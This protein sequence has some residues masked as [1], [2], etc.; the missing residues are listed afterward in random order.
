[1]IGTCLKRAERVGFHRWRKT[2][3]ET[4]VNNGNDIVLVVDYHLENLE[5][6][7]L[8]QATGEERC[9]RSKN[10]SRE[11]L[12]L[13]Q[14]AQVE[15]D[16]RGAKVVWIM[17]STSGW[18]RVK[19][20]LGDRAEFLLANVLQMP[21]PPK[22]RR[23][24]TDKI[25]TARMLREYCNGTLPLAYQPLAELRQVRRLVDARQDLVRRQTALKNW[26]SHYLSHET[27]YGTDNLWSDRGLKRLKSLAL[28]KTDRWLLDLK[29]TELEQVLLLVEQV[30]CQIMEVYRRWPEAE[31][32]D[33]VRGI[34]PISAVTILAYIGPIDR[35]AGAEELI[36]FA[37]LAPGVHRSDGRG[38]SGRTG[39]GGT[40]SRLRYF[41][42]EATHWLKDIPRYAAAYQRVVGKRGKKVARVVLARMFLRS[43]DKILRAGLRFAPEAE[44]VA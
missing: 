2:P 22:A 19:D 6:R 12:H 28:P 15:A 21:L 8:N 1:M 11:I 41:L 9:F 36:S 13:V 14:Q 43:L 31:R 32:L 7:Q 39:G 16:L 29:I 37:G 26:L 5:L 38:Y 25:D 3:K 40:H 44:A 35:F 42:I 24:K 23:R 27:W 10:T 20:L 4:A 18:A 34:G 30:E 33:E 17:E